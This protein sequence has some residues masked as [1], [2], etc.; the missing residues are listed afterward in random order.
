MHLSISTTNKKAYVT[1]VNQS[2][3]DAGASPELPLYHPVFSYELDQSDYINQ[4]QEQAFSV[5]TPTG[6][7]IRQI[8][9]TGALT[10]YEPSKQGGIIR[11]ADP[12]GALSLNTK[13]QTLDSGINQSDLVPPLFLAVTA[14]L[15]KNTRPDGKPYRWVAL[16]CR[17][18]TR[19]ERDNWIL[20]AATSLL[21]RL[22]EMNNFLLT[23][24]G[25][26]TLVLVRNH[27]QVS[28]GHLKNLGEL[29]AKA[30]KVVKEP[31]P[32][33]EPSECIMSVIREY[34]GPKGIHIDDIY[35]YT[36]RAALADDMVRD[37]IKVLIAEDEVY[38]PS[39]GYIRLL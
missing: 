23:G 1:A 36:R 16:T 7:S 10:S 4:G 17:I 15:E 14:A 29:A 5:I 35:K 31:G 24:Q 8:W 11:I 25:T 30:L 21:Q 2:L 32:P 20:A 38:Q 33:I 6:L 37:T 13:P 28:P 19:E 18:A 27:Y 9:M 39:P 26:E 22:E 34:S 12:T 3:A